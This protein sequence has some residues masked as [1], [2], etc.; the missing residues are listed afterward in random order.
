MVTD[1]VGHRFLHWDSTTR[2][3][4]G[5]YP[6]ATGEGAVKPA[7]GH[8]N[9]KRPDLK[10]VVMTLPCNPEGMPLCGE[11]RDGNSSDNRRTS[12]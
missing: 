5:E 6:T 9:Q 8:S 1:Q 11:V 3:L 4:Y 2:M 12:R 10:Q 7:Y